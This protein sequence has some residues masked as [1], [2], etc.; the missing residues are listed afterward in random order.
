MP[1]PKPPGIAAFPPRATGNMLSRMRW[2]VTSGSVDGR[3]AAT[4][5]GVR[6]GQRCVIASVRSR[7][8]ASRSVRENRVL[9]IFATIDD[10]D[11]FTLGIRRRD[12]LL[13]D[14]ARRDELA[15]DRA[16]A[17][18]G[19]ASDAGSE[20][21]RSRARLAHAGLHEKRIGTGKRPQQSVED[22]TEQPRTERISRAG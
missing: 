21:E 2:P 7:P 5:R 20:R 22:V 3:R 12:A 19:A 13:R 18:R 15:E 9:R 17:H 1:V 10:R 16:A 8:L 4:G 14:A 6:T 11:D